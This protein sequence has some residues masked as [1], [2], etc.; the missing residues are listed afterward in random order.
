M[1]NQKL[2]FASLSFMLAL[3]P[4]ASAELIIQGQV[5]SQNYDIDHWVI[6]PHDA[7][8]S[9]IPINSGNLYIG[10]NENGSITLNSNSGSNEITAL[11]YDYK[12]NENDSY[13]N[14]ATTYLGYS[15]GITGTLN[16]TGINGNSNRPIF[17]TH[18][19][20]IGKE[21]T[22]VFTV[23]NG[24]L[25]SIE[26]DVDN[27]ESPGSNGTI[28]VQGVN[29][30]GTVSTL[31]GF[32]YSNARSG[33]GTT[34]ISDGG[35]VQAT[36]FFDNGGGYGSNG[37][38]NIQGVNANGTASTLI[39]NSLTNGIF[40]NGKITISDGGF[41]QNNYDFRSGSFLGAN[42]TLQIKGVSANGTASAMITKNFY[43][44]ISGNA[45]ATIS[46]GGT[47]DVL[48]T[49]KNGVEIGATGTLNINGVNTNGHASKLSTYQFITGVN[50][51]GVT[52][53]SDGAQ[54][55]ISYAKYIAQNQG[56]KGILNLDGI[57]A[58]GSISTLHTI[59]LENGDK[60]TANLNISRGAQLIV[61]GY[62][63]QNNLST[64]SI[65]LSQNYLST[66][67]H[68]AITGNTD[69]TSPL[70]NGVTEVALDGFLSI[71]LDMGD[72]LLQ[73]N[74]YYNLIQIVG[75]AGNLFGQFENLTEGQLITSFNQFDIHLTYQGGDGNDIQVYVIENDP[76]HGDTNG[77]DLINQ[78]DLD[79]VKQHLGTNSIL[80]DANHD[81][82][83]DL[84]DLF[85]IRN[86]MTAQAAAIPEPT[87]L[88]TIFALAPALLRR[89]AN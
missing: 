26:D 79:L 23:S 36:G 15:A 38:L 81:G 82:Q 12:Y 21:G 29:S 7:T 76:I 88:F 67:N 4:L 50:G 2:K 77:D 35:L 65:S 1:K 89:R 57:N 66:A 61:D 48:G 13:V 40:G 8:T 51:S 17:Q 10:S 20:F 70:A 16:L 87:T 45:S 31:T 68:W 18:D 72:G 6:T 60:G 41:V 78:L 59:V 24:A 54:V 53:I 80:G 3:T 47:L 39:A 69:L 75:D 63:A 62:Y 52:N 19:F 46:D 14:A 44:A 55:Q 71:V 34:N 25:A 32:E 73:H 56:S 49:I 42:G 86:I 5:N 33:N 9:A 22:G 11:L 37:I 74:Q 85:T 43:N 30:N 27:A 58:N 84:A 64:L 28:N 83:T